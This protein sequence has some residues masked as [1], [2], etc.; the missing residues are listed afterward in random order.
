MQWVLDRLQALAG[1]RVEVRQRVVEKR[2]A[3][4]RALSADARKL[5]TETG[6]APRHTLDQTLTDTLAYWSEHT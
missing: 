5:R 6:W 4:P 2:A 3:D 1:V